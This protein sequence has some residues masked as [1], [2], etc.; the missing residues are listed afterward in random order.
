[1]ADTMHLSKEELIARAQADMER[2]TRRNGRC[3]RSWR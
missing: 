3:A 1:M 2:K